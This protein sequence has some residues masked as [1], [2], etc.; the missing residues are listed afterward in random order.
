MHRGGNAIAKA[1]RAHAEN[2]E[3]EA[4]R[5]RSSELTLLSEFFDS[6]V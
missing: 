6:E 4:D 3:A 5:E 2:V 1:A